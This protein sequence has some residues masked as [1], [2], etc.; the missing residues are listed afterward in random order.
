MESVGDL[1][2]GQFP[3]EI[4]SGSDEKQVVQSM[5]DGYN[6][7]PGNKSES[8]GFYHCEL[9]NDKGIYAYMKFDETYQKWRDAYSQCNCGQKRQALRKIIASG[10][11]DAIKDCTFD[12]YQVL[13]GWQKSVKD[14]ALHF[15]EK[16]GQVFFFGGQSG[17]GKT[18]LCTSNVPI[19]QRTQYQV[20]DMAERASCD[21]GTCE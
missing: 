18:H 13:H 1:L 9:C 8:D 7:I 11:G 4:V 2:K 3:G 20:Y 17:A 21:A 10:L 14:K 16:G 5:V 15:C 6:A 12:S 19:Q